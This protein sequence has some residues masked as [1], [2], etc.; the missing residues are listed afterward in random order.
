MGGGQLPSETTGPVAEAAKVQTTVIPAYIALEHATALA[1]D[2]PLG[3]R[4]QTPV[5]VC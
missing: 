1:V 4:S 5:C 2:G 3:G